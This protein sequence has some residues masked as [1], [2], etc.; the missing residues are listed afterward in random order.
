MTCSR[1]RPLRAVSRFRGVSGAV[2][3]A[4]L[5]LQAAAIAQTPAFTQYPLPSGSFADGIISGPGSAMWFT[6]LANGKVGS[7]KTEGT[8]SAVI[9]VITE[10]TVAPPFGGTDFV[11]D[12]AFITVGPDG[13]LWFTEGNQVGRVTAAGASTLYPLPGAFDQP[14]GIAAG[15]DGALW[16]A[17]T[18]GNRIGRITTSGALLEYPVPTFASAPQNI[19]VG[20][21]HALWFTEWGGNRIGRITTAGVV[22]EYPIP[23]PNANA[24]GIV[25][26]PDGALWFAEFD[27]YKIGRISTDGAISEYA[28]PSAGHPQLITAG[29]D[30]ALWFTEYEGRLG[31]ITPGGAIS[32]YDV[33]GQG[34]AS[35]FDITTGPDGALWFTEGTHNYSA[36]GSAIGR[37][38]LTPLPVVSSVS[39]SATGISAKSIAAGELITIEGANLGPASPASGRSFTV[40][41]QGGVS[42]TLAGVQVLFGNTTGTPIFVSPGQINVVVPWEIA[43]QTS[44]SLVVTYN[45]SQSTAVTLSVVSVA[46]AIY[47]LDSTGSG[48]AAALNLTG[49]SAGAFNG[50]AAGVI[51]GGS[52]VPT[53]PASQG[54]FLA[55]FL[56][57]GGQ[58]NPASATGSVNPPG[59]LPLMNW[60]AGSSVVTATIG[61]QPAV[62]QYA[63]A[64][65]GFVAGV[66]QVNLQV[67]AGVS[68]NGLPVAI[69]IDGVQTQTAA[70]IA[71]QPSASNE[72][73]REFDAGDHQ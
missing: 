4:I 37:A 20:P 48:Q 24:F 43:G 38:A 8:S 22:A 21:D 60:T 71:V 12:E 56:T 72:Q 11:G 53:S 17:E 59:P 13:A 57:G 2:R 58:T 9:T 61:G 52:V 25:S 29:S 42:S 3:I 23:T 6:D 54:A 1:R 41:A 5:A 18:G 39:N 31:R 62:V 36:Q 30:G 10:Y 44:T 55:L 26:G 66:V 67:P 63:G 45:G 34:S 19:A 7:I 28:I 14:V 27:G 40:N 50:P 73:L 65:P 16:F 68:G 35:L 47:T 49:S 32:E 69:A 64:A 15:P 51:V 70:T 46:P 33:P